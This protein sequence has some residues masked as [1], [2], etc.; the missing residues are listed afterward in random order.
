M[1]PHANQKGFTLIE[2]MAM[3]VILG[4]LVSV[5]IK[6]FGVIADTAAISGL[7]VGISEL[8]ARETIVWTNHL[9]TTSGTIDDALVWDDIDPDLGP[10][11]DWTV[12]PNIGGGQLSYSGQSAVL[13]RT[14]STSSRAGRWNS[15]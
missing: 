15:I 2:M 7:Q 3:L 10:G 4:I 8:N 5:S 14:A 13:T 12:G 6:K 1:I 9:F 11:Y